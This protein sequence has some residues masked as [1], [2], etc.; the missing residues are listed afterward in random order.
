M[1][2]ML[3]VLLCADKLSSSAEKEN[4]LFGMACF[5]ITMFGTINVAEKEYLLQL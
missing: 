3:K 4:N 2:T 1:I 5:C